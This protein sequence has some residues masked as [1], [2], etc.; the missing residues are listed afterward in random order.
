MQ[1]K[2]RTIRDIQIPRRRGDE[3]HMKKEVESGARLLL[4]EVKNCRQSS[5]GSYTVPRGSRGTWSPSPDFAP[6]TSRTL[7]RILSVVFSPFLVTFCNSCH[8][9]RTTPPGVLTHLTPFTGELTAGEKKGLR[10]WLGDGKLAYCAWHPMFIP[11]QTQ[12]EA[13][14]M[15][16]KQDTKPGK[17]PTWGLMPGSPEIRKLR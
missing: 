6:L 16:L 9:C 3:G 7:E 8:K 13:G 14:Q 15:K 11:C 12:K 2:E 17:T 5:L 4:Q 10:V 1:R